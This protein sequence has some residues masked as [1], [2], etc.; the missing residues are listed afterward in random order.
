MNLLKFIKKSSKKMENISENKG[1]VTEKTFIEN[2][3]YLTELT[4]IITL[5][6]QK[7]QNNPNFLNN[8][9]LVILKGNHITH[10]LL[11]HKYIFINRQN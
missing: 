4:K 5:I 2:Y 1:S 7:Y 3:T 9:H 8:Q 6:K 10:V 11:Y